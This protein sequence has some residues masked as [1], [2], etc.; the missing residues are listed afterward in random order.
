MIQ[1]EH[2]PFIGLPSQY[3][4][5]SM[6]QQLVVDRNDRVLFLLSPR[7]IGSVE[8]LNNLAKVLES[9]DVSFVY[10]VEGQH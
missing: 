8:A 3:S 4:T 10:D 5:T 2:G 6:L 9:R 7:W 1:R